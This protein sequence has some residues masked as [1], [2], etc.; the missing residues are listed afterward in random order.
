MS[1]APRAV[2]QIDL[3]A[4]RHNLARV[5][6]YAPRARVM[7]AV[8][9]NAYGHGAVPVAR[10][11]QDAGCEAFA[12]ATLDEGLVLRQAGITRPIALLNG[13]M[14]AEALYQAVEQQLQVVVHDGE[15]LELL[16]SQAC[17]RGTAVWVKLDTG[18]H[19]L[20]LAPEAVGEVAHRLDR[21]NIQIEGW[22]THL[23]CADDVRSSVTRRQRETFESALDGH[24]EPR[25]V[26][27][28]AGIVAWPQTHAEWV[29]PGIML[30]GGAPLAD[31]QA[32]DHGLKPVM[33]FST[34]LLSTRVLA[35]GEGIGYG[36]NWTAPETLQVGIVAA[37]YG[38]GYPRH[39]PS[40][41]PVLI[42]GRRVPLIGRVSMDLIAV[43]LRDCPNAAVGDEIVL[44][45][46]PELPVELVAGPARTISYELFCRLTGRVR[47]NYSS[48]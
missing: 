28:S 43:D 1:P 39:A 37:G 26:A 48:A 46:A 15:Q 2:A 16:E 45:G 7:A 38:D 18:M 19:R 36:L 10:T 23:A 42:R 44:W 13:V 24:P 11:L 4:L 20:G 17:A 33:H 34:V 32:V 21:L 47:F 29:R 8:K 25:S 6:H 14:N 40:G 31:G 12:V 5:R 9:A 30:Y 27:N 22:M 41:T 3:S 35:A